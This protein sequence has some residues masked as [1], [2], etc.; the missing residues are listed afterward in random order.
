MRTSA[1]SEEEV[2][3]HED[4]SGEEV[5][6]HE[7]ESEEEVHEHEDESEEEVHEHEDESG[8]EVHEHEDESEEEVHE[9]EEEEEPEYEEQVARADSDEQTY[10]QP[11]LVIP[12]R[13][14]PYFA[15][16]TREFD[17]RT[18]HPA[19][20]F[21]EH[22]ET[23]FGTGSGVIGAVGTPPIPDAPQSSKGTDGSSKATQTQK[24]RGLSRQRFAI[25]RGKS[26]SMP[27]ID[28]KNGERVEASGNQKPV[29][30]GAKTGR[31]EPCPC[32]SGRKYKRCC[33]TQP[34]A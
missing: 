21:G 8:E 24:R 14:I 25:P 7:D 10:G 19:N 5:H 2:H 22:E 6:E 28:G 18:R 3:E 29:R 1:T 11:A 9:H 30:V 32:G 15:E 17:I 23:T 13:P 4:E 34:A 16:G 31:N 26:K 12:S 20:E 33:R 27:W